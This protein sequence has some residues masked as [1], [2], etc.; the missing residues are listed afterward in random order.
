MDYSPP[1]LLIHLVIPSRM[2]PK[3]SEHFVCMV[4]CKFPYQLLVV[5]IEK[6]GRKGGVHLDFSALQ[7]LRYFTKT[8]CRHQGSF[9]LL[10][11]L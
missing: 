10:N 11:K 9:R 5:L 4:L 2:T 6:Q 1:S 8:H 7:V 3:G